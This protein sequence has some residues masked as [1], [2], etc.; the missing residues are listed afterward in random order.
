MTTPQ[1]NCRKLVELVSDY[2]EGSLT[3]AA[4]ADL[5][6]HLAD[7][8]DCTEYVRQIEKTIAALGRLRTSDLP[9]TLRTALMS[10][11][12]EEIR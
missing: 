3:T 2:L 8:Q 10:T 11:T 6:T 12:S 5:E 9:E 4:R 7:C 1:M